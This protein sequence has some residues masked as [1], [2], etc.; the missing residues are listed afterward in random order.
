MQPVRGFQE[1]G[2]LGL[3]KGMGKG[4][5]GL[6]LR[7]AV[8]VV[9]VFTRTAEG[10]QNMGNY[11]GDEDRRARIRPPRFDFFLFLFFFFFFLFLFFLFAF[12]FFFFFFFM[13][14]WNFFQKNNLKHPDLST[15]MRSF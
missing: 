14:Y 12:V 6:V 13:F 8:G 2:G 7:P 3:V 11:L 9:D 5:A 1:E 4:A 15:K 10:L